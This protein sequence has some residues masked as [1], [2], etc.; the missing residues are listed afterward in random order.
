MKTC[1]FAV[2]SFTSPRTLVRQNAPHRGVAH[3]SCGAKYNQVK[4]YVR[5]GIGKSQR[6]HFTLMYS[7]TF[8]FSPATI[9]PCE[10]TRW[11]ASCASCQSSPKWSKWPSPTGKTFCFA[12]KKSFFYFFVIYFQNDSTKAGDFHY[13]SDSEE[14]EVETTKESGDRISCNFV[15]YTNARSLGL[16]G[17]GGSRF[18]G[19]HLSSEYATRHMLTNGMFKESLIYR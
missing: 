7:R 13:Y 18:F 3:E 12:R 15:D 2:L 8:E 16:G 10:S 1:F 5:P 19:N 6:F 14:D 9:Q 17:S 11:W 4:W